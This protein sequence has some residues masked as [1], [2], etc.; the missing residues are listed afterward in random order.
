MNP[1]Q[2]EEGTCRSRAAPAPKRLAAARLQDVWPRSASSAAAEK[3]KKD[4]QS[5]TSALGSTKSFNYGERGIVALW[6]ELTD[7]A[8]VLA[9]GL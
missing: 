7:G 2:L 8:R 6:L 4:T 5:L 3:N 1:A 9:A